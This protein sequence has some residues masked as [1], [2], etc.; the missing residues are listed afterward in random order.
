[1]FLE[2][3]RVKGQIL[4]TVITYMTTWE[5]LSCEVFGRRWFDMWAR[6][7]TE[8]FR[9]SNLIVTETYFTQNNIK[10]LRRRKFNL[11]SQT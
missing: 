1:M 7:V 9:F 3:E 8:M 6:Y 5:C 2:Q 4:S 11:E 10:R